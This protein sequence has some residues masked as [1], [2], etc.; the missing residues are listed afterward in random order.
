MS[1][2]RLTFLVVLLAAGAASRSAQAAFHRFTYSSGAECNPSS[3]QTDFVSYSERGIKVMDQAPPTPM[4]SVAVICPVPWSQDNSLPWAQ[5]AQS[6]SIQLYMQRDPLPPSASSTA[7]TD[8]PGCMALASGPAGSMIF[9]PTVTIIDP[10]TDNP[11]Y[12]LQQ[13]EPMPVGTVFAT[14]LYCDGVVSGTSIIGYSVDI[15]YANDLSSC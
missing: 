2:S 1:R 6:I 3:P 7:P 10:G 14:A 4:R 8:D 9:I 13:S 11:I 15:C 12:V 5:P